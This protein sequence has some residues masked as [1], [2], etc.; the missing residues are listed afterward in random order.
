MRKTETGGAGG[1]RAPD[2]NLSER[3]ADNMAL[4]MYHYIGE[5]QEALRHI[6][7][8]RKACTADFAALFRENAPDRVY[9]IASGTSYNGALA[10]APF[11]EETLGIE[12][13]AHPSS[14]LPAIRGA[15]PLIVFISQG[16]HSTNTLDAIE[17]LRGYE[18]LALT[19][20]EEC[21]VNEV[22]A[23]HVLI[24]CGPEEAGPKTKGYVSTVLTLYLMALEGALVSG[25]RT[26]AAYAEAVDALGQAVERMDKNI[27]AAEKWVDENTDWLAGTAHYILVGKHQ[28][29]LV[30]REGALKLVETVLT[31]AASYEFEEFLHGPIGLIAEQLGGIYLLPPQDDPDCARMLA[32]AQF[33]AEHS[34]RVCIV[35]SDPAAQG[36]HVLALDAAGPWYTRPFAYILPC[37]LIS[38]KLPE[39]MEVGDRGM[40]IFK[41]VDARLS[42]KYGHKG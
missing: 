21:R 17:A 28:D 25:A 31:P 22:C 37:Q 6:L 16:G 27:A 38:A 18:S 11:M 2:P 32:L 4:S 34:G 15:R 14:M 13:T 26:E 24:A 29:G 10:A 8:E 19:G 5:Q 39:K 41:Q 36:E 23:H 35:S 40:E 1:C 3:M 33:H 42:I 7:R 20:A 9:L 30:A 12:V